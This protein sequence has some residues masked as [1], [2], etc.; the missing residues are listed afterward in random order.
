MARNQKYRMQNVS[1]LGQSKYQ[2]HLKNERQSCSSLLFSTH[3]DLVSDL[4]RHD[5]RSFELWKLERLWK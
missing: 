1:K 2:E 4:L 3:Y 5:R